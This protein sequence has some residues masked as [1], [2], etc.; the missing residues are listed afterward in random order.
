MDASAIE[1]YDR[2]RTLTAE[3]ERKAHLAF[4]TL[5]GIDSRRAEL[6]MQYADNKLH[7]IAALLT[8]EFEVTRNEHDAQNSR[9]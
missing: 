3:I 8:L 2:L 1:K 7:E 6:A 9:T 4:F 5:N